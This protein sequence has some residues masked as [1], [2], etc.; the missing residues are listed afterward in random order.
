[1][2]EELQELLLAREQALAVREEK[3]GIS[4]KALAKV[5]VETRKTHVQGSRGPW[6]APYPWDPPGF[7]HGW[8]CPRGGGLYL[9]APAGSLHI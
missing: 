5:S 1:M 2:T 8:R 4:E 7:A 9:G 6:H 3:A